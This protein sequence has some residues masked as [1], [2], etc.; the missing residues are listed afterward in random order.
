MKIVITG[1]PGS[2][3]STLAKELAAELRCEYI[4]LNVIAKKFA[5]LKK[6]SAREFEIDLKKLQN[7]LQ[8][9]LKN[10][11]NFVLD[12]HLACEIKI[13][14]DL[15]V[16]LRCNPRVLQKRLAKR[17][18]AREKLFDNLLAEAQDYFPI[19]VERFY[20]KNF[21][22]INSTKRVSLAKLLKAIKQRKG[23]KVNWGKELFWLASQGL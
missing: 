11:T 23:E 10:K 8:K 20:K 16:I 9:S 1:V 7:V 2:G 12:G 22:E 21:V 14:C 6:T 5:V 3:K 19:L 13:P 18:Y 15:V 4:D 17:H